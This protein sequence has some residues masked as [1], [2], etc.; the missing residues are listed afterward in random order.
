MTSIHF[1]WPP[2]I[3]LERKWIISKGGIIPARETLFAFEASSQV[4]QEGE[5]AAIII[6]EDTSTEKKENTNTHVV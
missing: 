5:K 6:L 4:S 3:Q 2:Y 1:L